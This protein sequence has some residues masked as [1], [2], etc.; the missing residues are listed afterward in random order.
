MCA[1]THDDTEAEDRT[2]ALDKA[3]TNHPQQMAELNAL[4]MVP[5]VP[6]K[7]DFLV[8]LA[9]RLEDHEYEN[10]PTRNVDAWPN[11]NY[12]VYDPLAGVFSAMADNPEAAQRYLAPDGG[13]NAKDRW[14]P[15]EEGEKRWALLRDR[16]WS[17]TTSVNSTTL[18]IFTSVQAAASS[19]RG[20]DNTDQARAATWATAQS[21]DFAVNNL[22][23]DNYTDTMKE[24][25]SVLIANSPDEVVQVAQGEVRTVWASPA[26]KMRTRALLPH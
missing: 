14:T 3:V 5:D 6:Y 23:T 13:L 7:T 10:N 21:M 17:S 9:D 18:D 8:H 1:A 19:L 25:F 20:S 15:G 16:D 24:N 22:S 12:K 26:M 4:L 11:G 2:A